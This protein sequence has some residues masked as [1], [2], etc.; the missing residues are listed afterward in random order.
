[1]PTGFAGEHLA[2]CPIAQRLMRPFIVVKPQ[3]AA[4]PRRASGTEPY[5]LVKTSSYFRLRHSRSMKMLSRN[6]PLP[7]MLIRMPA[8]SSS[9]RN[10]ALVN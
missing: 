4:D 2:R 8:A 7:S 6:R 3:P 1:M 10:P 9:S 5:A